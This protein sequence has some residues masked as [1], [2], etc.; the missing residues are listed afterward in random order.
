MRAPDSSMATNATEHSR[1][2]SNRENVIEHLFIGELLRCLWLR[3]VYNAEVLRSEV[4]S[5]G[6]D[7][8]VDCD[9]LIRHIQLKA[10]HRTAK[11]S[12]QNVNVELSKKLSGCVIWI[13]FDERTLELGPFKWFGGPV[14]Q[15][16]RS[17]GNRVAR[18]TKGNSEGI[19]T[20]R[21]NI[22]TIRKKEFD[23]IENMEKLIE[24]L[25]GSNKSK[26]SSSQ[27]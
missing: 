16:I 23:E 27:P 26:S 8:V 25:F 13:N 10:S 18:H 3:G 7:L 6:Y 20:E 4:D 15:P 19:K 21:K 11:T 1:F 24:A 14:G 9:G 12:Q 2:S 5:S 22:R 17:L